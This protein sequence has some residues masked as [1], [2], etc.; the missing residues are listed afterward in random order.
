M[1]GI[2]PKFEALPTE[3]AALFTAEVDLN[4]RGSFG[5]S[6]LVATADFIYRIEK[7]PLGDDI[8]GKWEVSKLRA[9]RVDDL[10]DATALVAW[11]GDVEVELLRGTAGKVLILANA[12]KQLQALLEGKDIPELEAELRLCAKCS[13]P[14]PKDSDICTACLNRGK[15]LLRLFEFARPYRMRLVWGTFLILGGT[16]LELLPP[17]LTQHLVDD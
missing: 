3:A 1:A 16:L 10:V 5:T 14:L 6:C 7:T 13:R 8:V 17:I 15:T 2:V 12:Q 4:E 9:P 11:Y